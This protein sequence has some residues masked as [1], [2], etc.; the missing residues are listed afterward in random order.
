MAK[1]YVTFGSGFAFKDHYLQIEADNEEFAREFMSLHFGQ[2]WA[3]IYSEE[4]F[5]HQIAEFGL[6]LLCSIDVRNIAFSGDPPVLDFAVK[7]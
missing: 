1:F 3:F 2:K 7:E 5:K 6:K 4:E